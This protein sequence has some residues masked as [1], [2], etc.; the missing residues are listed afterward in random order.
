MA[1]M[2]CAYSER[3]SCRT[4]Q[5]P[6]VGGAGGRG[7]GDVPRYREIF[8]ESIA[9]IISATNGGQRLSNSKG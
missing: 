2:I 7:N 9:T 4:A 3:I 8:V 6:I 5:K 1:V